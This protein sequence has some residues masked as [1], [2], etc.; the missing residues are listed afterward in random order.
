MLDTLRITLA[1]DGGTATDVAEER[2]EFVLHKRH[3]WILA[4]TGYWIRKSASGKSYELCCSKETA[5][6]YDRWFPFGTRW[7]ATSIL[8][9]T[10]FES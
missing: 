9:V 3:G 4:P 1:P 8:A 10:E 7:N 5:E 2:Y 6:A